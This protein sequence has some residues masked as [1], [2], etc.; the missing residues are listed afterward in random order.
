MFKHTYTKQIADSSNK[1]RKE[2]ALNEIK[3]KSFFEI[4]YGEAIP[5]TSGKAFCSI[6][7]SS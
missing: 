5:D 4:F 7:N 6:F 2:Q 3:K 1:Q